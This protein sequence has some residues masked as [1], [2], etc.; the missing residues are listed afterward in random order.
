MISVGAAGYY[1]YYMEGLNSR[2]PKIIQELIKGVT[3][4]YAKVYREETCFLKPK[5][6]YKNF[7]DCGLTRDGSKETLFIWGDS[8]A[9]HLYP[10]YKKIF[11]NK[12]NV[13]QRT[14]SA[15]PPIIGYQMPE[16]AFCEEINTKNFE[17]LQNIKPDRV[18]LSA[19]WIE[20]KDWEQIGHTIAQIKKAGVKKID[21]VG[22]MPSW[23]EA[24]PVLLYKYF[25]QDKRH[26]IPKRM[27]FGLNKEFVQVDFL[28]KAFARK[29]DIHYI[30]PSDIICTKEGCLTRVGKTKNSLTAWD[31]D[32]LTRL[33]SIYLVSKFPQI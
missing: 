1:I 28:M 3:Y 8:H 11:G 6:N 24:L 7:A 17:L 4:D 20:Y 30:S 26:R 12:Y 9:A 5:Q 32:H 18:I 13:I 33:S 10:G 16:R 2:F 27:S 22:P 25:L 31:T 19:K 21:L 29:N 15:C 23:T 14:A